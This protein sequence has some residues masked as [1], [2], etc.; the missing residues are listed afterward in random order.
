MKFLNR[1]YRSD[2]R[3]KPLDIAHLDLSGIRNLKLFLADF[4]GLSAFQTRQGSR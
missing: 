3:K 2:H 1:P 4:Q